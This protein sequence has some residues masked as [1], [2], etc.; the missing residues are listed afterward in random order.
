M[1]FCWEPEGRYQYSKMFLWE[2][3]GHYQYSK[4]F[5]WEPEG[6]YGF[7][8]SMAITPLWFSMEHLWIVIAPFWLSTDD[9][10][11]TQEQVSPFRHII[12]NAQNFISPCIHYTELPT[13]TFLPY[14]VRFFKGK[15]GSTF[16]PA[17][18]RFFFF[19][20]LYF[21]LLVLKFTRII[22][23]MNVFE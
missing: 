5:C 18:I 10:L 2:P 1:M 22:Y 19:F 8:M 14:F 16:F 6:H 21:F 11:S 23:V 20:F 7:T 12:H 9:M 13:S 15:Y 3:E 17:K 4:M